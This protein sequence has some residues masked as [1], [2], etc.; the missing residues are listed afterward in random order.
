VNALI[1]WFEKSHRPLPWRDPQC[2]PWGVMVS[3]VML[4]QTPVSRVLP[5]FDAWMERWPTAESL[6]QDSV[7]EALKAWGRLGYPRRAKRLH[8]AAVIITHTHQGDVPRDL[9]A[10]RALPGIGEYTARAIRTFAFGIPEPIVDTNIRRVIARAVLGDASAGPVRAVL[11][12]QRVGEFLSPIAD[13]ARACTAAAGLMELGA[14]IC[15]PRNPACDQCPLASSCTWKAS[16][17]PEYQGAAPPKQ[18]HYQGSDRM[19]R[20][21]ILRELRSSDTPIPQTFLGTLWPERE[22][23]QRALR[24]LEADGLIRRSPVEQNSYELPH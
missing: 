3:E 20:G 7:A 22:Q 16:G 14:L 6:A 19:V 13:P 11:D 1:D 4:Q 12:R 24:S 5:Q 21:I 2:G 8:E 18:A 15:T 23:F 17:F 9:D 10:L